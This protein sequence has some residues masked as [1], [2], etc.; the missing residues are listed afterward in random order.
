MKINN[1]DLV[2]YEFGENPVPAIAFNGD[3]LPVA[4]S[5]QISNF[6]IE[7][8]MEQPVI[9]VG[10]Q[11]LST[12]SVVATTIENGNIV[13]TPAQTTGA[14]I[15]NAP[16]INNIKSVPDVK[17]MPNVVI[18]PISI[19]T[20]TVAENLTSLPSVNVAVNGV[21]TAQTDMNG[22]V[23]LPNISN[24]AQITFSYIG[25]EPQTY[26]AGFIPSQ[27][28]MKTTSIVLPEINIKSNPIPKPKKSYGWLWLLG[29]GTGVY[30]YNNSTSTKGSKL[31]APRVVV[32]KI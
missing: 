8:T 25:Y 29:I 11:N 31:N 1:S 10:N 21:P 2:L 20:T 18:L 19:R 7:N 26:T 27:I 13:I 5:P 16:V 24:D 9:I 12:A 6:E 28:V 32:A 3:P 4:Y 14:V 23:I 17:S 22:Q 30:I 15:N